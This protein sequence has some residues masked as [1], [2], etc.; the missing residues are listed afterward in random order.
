MKQTQ[1]YPDNRENNPVLALQKSC[2]LNSGTI[3]NPMGIDKHRFK[4]RYNFVYGTDLKIQVRL[5]YQHDGQ[6]K[7]VLR[8]MTYDDAYEFIA[9]RKFEL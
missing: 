1:Y 5:Q 2:F 7:E 8:E 6:Q 4:F 3:C 9:W